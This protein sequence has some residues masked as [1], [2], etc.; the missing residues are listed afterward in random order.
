MSR[1]YITIGD[2]NDI[3]GFFEK[4][5]DVNNTHFVS[6]FGNP[7]ESDIETLDFILSDVF[8]GKVLIQKY[9]DI[10]NN[11]YNDKHNS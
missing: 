5:N 8:G 10:Y 2:V 4:Y 11:R 3:K 7:T 1:E 9:A 6:L